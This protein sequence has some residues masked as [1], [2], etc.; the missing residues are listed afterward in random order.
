M[1]FVN[2][3]GAGARIY[4]GFRRRDCEVMQGDR[5]AHPVRWR[6]GSIGKFKGQTVRLR[7]VFHDATIWAFQVA[8][9]H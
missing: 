1:I 8:A 3:V 9:T 2:Y 4:N 6:G 5:L 7:F